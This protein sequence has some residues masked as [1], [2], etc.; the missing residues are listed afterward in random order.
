MK[1]PVTLSENAEINGQ[2][3][4]R[5]PSA[6]SQDADATKEFPPMRE[7]QVSTGS[8]N[9]TIHAEISDLEGYRAFQAM[10]LKFAVEHADHPIIRRMHAG[11]TGFWRLVAAYR[12]REKTKAE[13]EKG[14]EET[15]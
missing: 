11:D 6:Q 5:P 8:T 13:A 4:T 2:R 1:L 10:R 3:R 12:Q 7:L 14:S 15:P 9:I